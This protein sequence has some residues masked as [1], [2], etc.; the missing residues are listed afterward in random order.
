MDELNISE[1]TYI[2][3]LNTL[4][5]NGYNLLSGGDNRILHEETKEK[6]SKAH[7]K[8]KVI[9]VDI[10][11]NKEMCF[12]C[13]SDAGKEL[14]IDIGAIWNAAAGK[15]P[16]YKGYLWRFEGDPSK[17]YNPKTFPKAKLVIGICSKTGEIKEYKSAHSAMKDGFISAGIKN[18]LYGKAKTHK[19]YYWKYKEEVQKWQ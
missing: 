7:K 15:L 3:E 11:T 1:D 8:R 12:G 6:I 5:P 19:N 9:A 2:K 18:C 10:K 16:S 14:K 17:E 13:C 4:S